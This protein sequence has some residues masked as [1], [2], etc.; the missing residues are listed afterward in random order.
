[1]SSNTVSAAPSSTATRGWCKTTVHRF[2]DSRRALPLA[3]PFPVVGGLSLDAGSARP[4]VF[5]SRLAAAMARPGLLNHPKFRRLA[6]ILQEPIPHVLGYLE[7]MWSVG[8]ESGRALLGDAVDVEL[9]AQYPGTP[10]KL[11]DALLSCR[12]IDLVDADRYA[13]HD[14]MDHAPEYVAGRAAR[15]AEREKEKTCGHCQ[16]VYHSADQRSKFCSPACRQASWRDAHPQEVADRNGRKRNSP[17]RD[18]NSDADVTERNGELRTVTERNGSPAPAPA[19]NTNNPPSPQGEGEASPSAENTTDIPT[20]LQT[21][22]FL[23]AWTKWLNYLRQRSGKLPPRMTTE[24]H[25]AQCLA[26]GP[27]RAVAMIEHTISIGYAGLILPNGK[28]ANGPLPKPPETVDQKAAR[29]LAERR[30]AEEE[31]AAA[32][33]KPLSPETLKRLAEAAGRR[34]ET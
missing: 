5:V 12:L 1:M 29:C 32:N 25:I 26:V 9:A 16:A 13:I 4:G 21:P 22:L 34:P 18:R 8:Y 7:C 6:H 20:T 11:F 15:E 23:A 2:A 28:Q 33:A 27:L 31:K 14:L 17:L 30:R 19:P 3:G 24:A 10:G